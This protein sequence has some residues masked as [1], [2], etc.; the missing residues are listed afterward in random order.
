MSGPGSSK[1]GQSI[2]PQIPLAPA[3]RVQARFN[4]LADGLIYLVV[5]VGGFLGVGLR[6]VLNVL[7]PPSGSVFDP[8]T[9]V[10][11]ILAC[12]LL[13]MLTEYMASA[14]WI[15]KR[16]RQVASKGL[17]MGFAGGLSTM[18][19]LMVST[20]EGLRD[21]QPVSTLAYLACT[22]VCSLIAAAL[23]VALM[24]WFLSK[25]IGKHMTYV[26]SRA[27]GRDSNGDMPANGTAGARTAAQRAR[28]EVR[29][30]KV[31]DV[32]HSAAQAA[33]E[34]AAVAQKAAAQAVQA[35]QG[36]SIDVQNPAEIQQ[37]SALANLVDPNPVTA[38]I[39]LVADPATEE[40]R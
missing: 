36:D 15:R 29:Q 23:G 9:F 1:G 28:T 33:L 14:S 22:F 25:L 40:V 16:I 10:S 37:S 12:F 39:P 3:K 26:M 21:Q 34:A 17:G 5:F 32:A 11:N 20:V 2:P 30:M 8:G 18:S 6:H 24:R 19:G 35:A 38:E 7:M 27:D 13:A 4:P 31:A